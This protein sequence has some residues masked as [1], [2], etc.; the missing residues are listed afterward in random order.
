VE[1]DAGA[2]TE[3]RLQGTLVVESLMLLLDQFGCI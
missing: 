2:I 1:H 3:F